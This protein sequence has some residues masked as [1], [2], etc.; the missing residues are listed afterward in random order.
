MRAAGE[1]EV[2]GHQAAGPLGSCEPMAGIVGVNGRVIDG[3]VAGH[4]LME[5]V[6][7]VARYQLAARPVTGDQIQ[8]I[9]GIGESVCPIRR[10]GATGRG[11]GVQDAGRLFPAVAFGVGV[12]G[13]GVGQDPRH[14][15]GVG[16]G[17]A[18]EP[19]VRLAR[20]IVPGLLAAL[21]R[22][23]GAGLAP[24]GK[25]LGDQSRVVVAAQPM[26]EDGDVVIVVREV[27][28]I[29]TRSEG[30]VEARI[31][32]LVPMKTVA[33]VPSR[34]CPGCWAR[35]KS[36]EHRGPDNWRGAGWCSMLS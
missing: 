10:A 8:A 34:C 13:V 20:V 33:R 14:Q 7:S 16:V 27:V 1:V 30:A 18:R 15:E 35:E 11:V 32:E 12:A 25:G 6:V 5:A 31:L 9:A 23:V 22:A 3:V 2:G 4:D 29:P 17:A 21:S 28:E 36:P 24:E 26:G 19:I